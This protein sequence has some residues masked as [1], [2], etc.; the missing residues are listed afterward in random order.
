MLKYFPELALKRVNSPSRLSGKKEKK[1]V[2]GEWEILRAPKR[3]EPA[4]GR[5][6]GSH[7]FTQAASGASEGARAETSG[8]HR[9]WVLSKIPLCT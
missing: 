5:A 6:L 1:G 8:R 4:F 9:Y 3:Q 7:S 2:E